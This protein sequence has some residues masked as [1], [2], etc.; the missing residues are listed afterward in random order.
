MIVLRGCPVADRSQNR[1]SSGVGFEEEGRPSLGGPN[2]KLIGTCSDFVTDLF[3]TK[4]D[5]F[6]ILINQPIP[7]G[8]AE[9][10]PVMEVLRLDKNVCV[11]EIGHYKTPT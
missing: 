9:I 4:N 7:E 2:S 3:D 6:F 8:R 1:K 11:Y 10:Q 5:S